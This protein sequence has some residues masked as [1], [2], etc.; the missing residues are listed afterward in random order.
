MFKMVYNFTMFKGID[1][2]LCCEQLRLRFERRGV[3]HGLLAQGSILG[4]P[5]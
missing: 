4:F 5:E 2:E 3:P 1:F